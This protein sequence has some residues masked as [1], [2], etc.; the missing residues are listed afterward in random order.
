MYAVN[1]P[2]YRESIVTVANVNLFGRTYA[3]PVVAK[4]RF[5][6]LQQRVVRQHQRIQDGYR[7]RLFAGGYRFLGRH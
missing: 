6:R 4:Q 3:H 7:Q 5:R 2:M 1:E